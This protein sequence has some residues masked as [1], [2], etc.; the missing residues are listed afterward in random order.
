MDELYD[1]VLV[2]CVLQFSSILSTL[3]HFRGLGEIN[4]NYEIA[5]KQYKRMGKVQFN[6]SFTV[7]ELQRIS[8]R[9]AAAVHERT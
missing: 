6:L 1:H 2:F 9:E 7:A 3:A 5:V 4:A 8:G